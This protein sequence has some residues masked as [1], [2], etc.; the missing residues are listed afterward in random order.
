MESPQILKTINLYQPNWFNILALKKDHFVIN[1]LIKDIL[2]GAVNIIKTQ[3]STMLC[4]VY[5]NTWVGDVLSVLMCVS[6]EDTATDDG[7]ARFH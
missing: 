1:D 6:G 7:I 5:K 3:L 4:A 2:T